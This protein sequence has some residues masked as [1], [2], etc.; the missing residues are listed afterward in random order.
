MD[1]WCISASPKHYHKHKIFIN[2]VCS[3]CLSDTIFF[4]HKYITQSTITP[5]DVIVKVFIDLM[6]TLKGMHD[7]N[8]QQQKN[9]IAKLH[10]TFKPPMISTFLLVPTAHSPKWDSMTSGNSA[11]TTHMLTHL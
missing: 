8:K 9:A 4:K 11:H 10:D 3:T 2:A 7:V 5:A 6:G 1:D